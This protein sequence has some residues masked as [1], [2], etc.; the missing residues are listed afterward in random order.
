[1]SYKY[2]YFTRTGEYGHIDLVTEWTDVIA[3]YP[4][5]GVIAIPTEHWTDAMWSALEA[6]KLEWRME[7]ANHIQV[8]IHYTDNSPVCKGCGLEKDTL[9]W[10][11][12]VKLPPSSYTPKRPTKAKKPVPVMDNEL[13]S[14][15]E[16]VVETVKEQHADEI[17]ATLNIINKEG[18]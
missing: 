2:S 10:K 9:A 8:G 13:R 3:R 12:G 11:P 1:M 14:T 16:D 15:L 6:T 7:V 17:Q 4:G 18:K 5:V